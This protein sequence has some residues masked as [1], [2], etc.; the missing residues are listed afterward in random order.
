LLSVGFSNNAFTASQNS[1]TFWYMG[2][3]SILFAIVTQERTSHATTPESPDRTSAAEP[4]GTAKS[5][6]EPGG[7]FGH[8]GF[9]LVEEAGG[10]RDPGCGIRDP[11]SGIRMLDSDAGFGIGLEIL[12]ISDK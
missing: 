12:V 10:M 3:S 8:S 5:H 7:V 6:A 4:L 1:I 2:K 9:G 11:G